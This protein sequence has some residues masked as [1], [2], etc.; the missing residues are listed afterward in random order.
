MPRIDTSWAEAPRQQRNGWAYKAAWFLPAVMLP[1][2]VTL[3]T[4]VVLF[5]MGLKG[6]LK[7]ANEHSM[8]I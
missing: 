3:L 2:A 5:C 1:H 8:P 6:W 7:L 4:S